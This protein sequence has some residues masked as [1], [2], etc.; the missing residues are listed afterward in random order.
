MSVSG[1]P[2]G[3]Q[4]E[5]V[6][7]PAQ[8]ADIR[9]ALASGWAD[10]RA[11]PLYGL[12]FGGIYALGGLVIVALMF[13]YG[14]GYLAYP[15]AAGFA[16]IGPFAAVGLYEV[17]RR[18]EVGEALDWPG[19]LRVVFAQGRR[20]IGWMAFITLFVLLMWMYQV[21]VLLA[22]FLGF[23]SFTTMAQ[24]LHVLVSTSDG[25]TFLLVGHLFGAVDSVILFSLTVVSFP[26]LLDQDR[27]FITAMVTS[28]KAVIASPPVMIVWALLIVVV[29]AL[30]L[31]PAFLGLLIAL[32][33]LGHATWHLYRRLVSFEAA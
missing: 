14:L 19:V 16:L 30:A 7:R 8:W 4:P 32:P 33:V 22:L 24:F 27:D 21:R 5:I 28:V 18:R 31:A 12:F 6:V 9:G 23:Q 26:L 29:L 20:E 1:T 3:Q 15:M 10:F 2:P 13:R 11:A 25:L 17:S